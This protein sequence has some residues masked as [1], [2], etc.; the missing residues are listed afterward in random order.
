MSTL[1]YGDFMK[2][3]LFTLSLSSLFA[4]NAFAVVDIRTDVFIETRSSSQTSSSAVPDV[5]FPTV[6][7]SVTFTYQVRTNDTKAFTDPSI[8]GNPCKLYDVIGQSKSILKSSSYQK[9]ST[10]LWV[11]KTSYQTYLL[12]DYVWN[13]SCD[14][15]H[16][17]DL[18]QQTY[19]NLGDYYFNEY[20][21][22]LDLAKH[23]D[24]TVRIVYNMRANT[25]L[26]LANKYYKYQ[27]YHSY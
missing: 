26:A 15:Y 14:V 27:E 9:A 24:S 11:Y 21:T 12:Y 5:S 10:K 17:S 20:E 16:H 6:K 4:T 18:M 8:S 25:A 3:A 23:S 22:F 2:V 19:K 13:V 7:N 1:Q